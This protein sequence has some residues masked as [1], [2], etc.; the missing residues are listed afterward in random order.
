MS[1]NYRTDFFQFENLTPING[2]PDFETIL[3]LKNEVKAN[4]QSVP[5]T[6]GGGNHGLLGLV[7]NPVEYALVSNTPFT[8]E[9]YP[10]ALTFPAGTTALQSKVLE[11]AYKKRLALYNA[12][13]GVEKAILQQI[14]KAVDEDWLSPL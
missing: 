4:A 10:G 8:S 9:P 14:V 5:T 7:I 11:D 13:I 12:C 1:I 2:E 3:K 6:L